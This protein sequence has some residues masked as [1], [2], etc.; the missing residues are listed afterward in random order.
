M[1]LND[2]VSYIQ[3]YKQQRQTVIPKIQA[4]SFRPPIKVCCTLNTSENGKG[5]VTAIS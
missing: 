4:L 1:K 5:L 2:G 3:I